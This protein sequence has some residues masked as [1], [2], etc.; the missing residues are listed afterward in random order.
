MA[1]IKATK[2]LEFLG[3]AKRF[4]P[5]E[6]SAYQLLEYL[7]EVDRGEAA[8]SEKMLDICRKAMM[9]I[10]IVKPQDR[11][12]GLYLVSRQYY[13]AGRVSEG[14][15][16][17]RMAMSIAESL[18]DGPLSSKAQLLL[19]N[20]L[21]AEGLYDLAG[22]QLIA[23][24][25]RANSM[26][27]MD[28][29]VAALNALGAAWQYQGMNKEA[30]DAYEQVYTVCR[31]SGRL[32][33]AL[34]TAM[35]QLCSCAFHTHDYDNVLRVSK[36]VL[37]K[38]QKLLTK[39]PSGL[40]RLAMLTQLLSV[41]MARLACEV[42]RFDEAKDLIKDIKVKEE[43][44]GGRRVMVSRMAVEGLI[45]VRQGQHRAG[46]T[47]VENAA[48]QSQFDQIFRH[49][50]EIVKARALFAADKKKEA[51]L[52]AAK[53]KDQQRRAAAKSADLYRKQ[54]M[55][56][57]KALDQTVSLLPDSPVSIMANQV[58]QDIRTSILPEQFRHSRGSK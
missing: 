40:T 24:Q 33:E 38:A 9:R 34:L 7:R 23:A 14:M 32:F 13:L 28:T 3:F 21:L 20:L 2:A 47:K 50:I 41:N 51:S 44:Y 37:R 43:D 6:I 8:P 29:Y 31:T 53:I 30:R 56:D 25:N 19:G 15:L 11:Y 1:S 16:P 5:T 12:E 58:A 45:E 57:L 46:L 17:A 27:D 10:E 52:L 39:D 54:S 48:K 42:K 36:P 26:Q 4:E 22:E 55:R 35:V 49:E 18:R